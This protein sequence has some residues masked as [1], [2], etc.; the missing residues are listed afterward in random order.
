MWL[1]TGR[2][3]HGGQPHQAPGDAQAAEVGVGE[4]MHTH[5]MQS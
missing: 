5:G 2:Q 1:G 3:G 4:N